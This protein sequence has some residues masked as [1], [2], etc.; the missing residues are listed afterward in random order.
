MPLQNSRCKWHWSDLYRS[1]HL[2]DLR[3]DGT[4]NFPEIDRPNRFVLSSASRIAIRKVDSCRSGF[5]RRKKC[6]REYILSDRCRGFS[7]RLVNVIARRNANGEK[8]E[9]RDEEI[10]PWCWS[11]KRRGRRVNFWFLCIN[12]LEFILWK[13]FARR[14]IFILRIFFFKYIYKVIFFWFL[15]LESVFYIFAFFLSLKMTQRRVET[16][17][18]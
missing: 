11:K 18:V 2:Y 5:L 4:L 9:I 6:L 16:F 3:M 14:L 15:H 12:I 1:S 8:T 10:E 13:S 17:K 7:T